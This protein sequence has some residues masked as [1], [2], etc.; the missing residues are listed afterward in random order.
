V[1]IDWGQVEGLDYS[2]VF[3]THTNV[4]VSV[5]ICRSITQLQV[6]LLGAHLGGSIRPMVAAWPGVRVRRLVPVS[7]SAPMALRGHQVGHHQ[8]LQVPTDHGLLTVQVFR[9]PGGG[10]AALLM[11][12]VEQLSATRKRSLRSYSSRSRLLSSSSRLTKAWR[13]LSPSC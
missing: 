10:E 12:G 5:R 13:G 2:D 1:R 3:V 11:Q 4:R 9:Q 7:S 6:E 8:L